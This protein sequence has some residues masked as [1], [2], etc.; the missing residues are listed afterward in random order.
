MICVKCN[1]ETNLL[2]YKY[3]MEGAVDFNNGGFCESCFTHPGYDFPENNLVKNNFTV[4]HKRG[5]L[6]S[7][8]EYE[9]YEQAELGAV[10]S[11]LEYLY[12]VENDSLMN[13]IIHTI[14]DGRFSDAIRYYNM[15]NPDKESIEIFKV[16]N[17]NN[18]YA[19]SNKLKN[20]LDTY[21]HNL[22]K[23]KD[24]DVKP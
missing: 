13:G 22:E 17:G 5:S 21:D 3:S 9:T 15:C 18:I 10:T 12:A 20:F 24:L 6:K 8:H 7:C 23:T 11:I 16:K 4:V 14:K 1:T 19:L 2:Q